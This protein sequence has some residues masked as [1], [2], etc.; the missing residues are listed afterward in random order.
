M[1]RFDLV[2]HLQ[3]SFGHQNKPADS[4]HK[5]ANAWLERMAHDRDGKERRG[6]FR[7]PVDAQQ[8]Q[9]ANAHCQCESPESGLFALIFG[10]AAAQNGDIDHIV[11]AQNDLQTAERDKGDEVVEGE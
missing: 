1:R 6:E 4:Q 11:D 10:Q 3:N 5:I 2:M 8:E 7:K 9:D